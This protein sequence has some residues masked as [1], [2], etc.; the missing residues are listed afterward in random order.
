M[1][2]LK[3]YVTLKPKE[4]V[5]SKLAIR[6]SDLN[7]HAHPEERDLYREFVARNYHISRKIQ[8]NLG[9]VIHDINNWTQNQVYLLEAQYGSGKSHFVAFLQL[10]LEQHKT[11]Q[12]M[13][14]KQS[15]TD[16]VQKKL[17]VV[18]IVLGFGRRNDDIEKIITE[19]VE[20][21][22]GRPIIPTSEIKNLMKNYQSGVLRSSLDDFITNELPPNEQDTIR[23]IL[24]T[25]DFN[26]IPSDKVE[27]A[28]GFTRKFYE[29]T[30][31]KASES[32]PVKDLLRTIWED[33]V[34]PHQE[35][36]EGVVYILE[37]FF[38]YTTSW[39]PEVGGYVG[40]KNPDIEH[41]HRS[42]Y[43]T[44]TD[45]STQFGQSHIIIISQDN[46]DIPSLSLMA[47]V[48]K[49][50]KEMMLEPEDFKDIILFR[51]FGPGHE[52]RKELMIKKW[53]TTHRSVVEHFTQYQDVM[54]YFPFIACFDEFRKVMAH[55]ATTRV[56]LPIAYDTVKRLLE[57]EEAIVSFDELVRSMII[58]GKVKGVNK[59]I[60]N[61]CL[62][63]IDLWRTRY[64]DKRLQDLKKAFL[65]LVGF[66]LI[67]R[68]GSK[69]DIA[70]V[71]I[72]LHFQKG[73]LDPLGSHVE[74]IK[75]LL[76]DLSRLKQVTASDEQMDGTVIYSYEEHEGTQSGPEFELQNQKKKVLDKFSDYLFKHHF[77]ISKRESYIARK[78][79]QDLSVFVENLLFR[80]NVVVKSETGPYT[81]Q[82]PEGQD[83]TLVIVP[84][85]NLIEGKPPAKQVLFWNLPELSGASQDILIEDM[86][87][88]EM[89][90]ARVSIGWAEGRLNQNLERVY[91][92]LR[93][94][95]IEGKIENED[96]EVN[97]QE[98]LTVDPMN[99]LS[100]ALKTLFLKPPNGLYCWYDNG[101]DPKYHFPKLSKK[102]DTNQRGNLINGFI[103][104]GE[105]A[106]LNVKGTR[107]E[108]S[109]FKSFARDF[110]IVDDRDPLNVTL[111]IK[112]PVCKK[113]KERF[114]S[115]LIMNESKADLAAIEKEFTQKPM[116]LRKEAF[117]VY[118]YTLVAKKNYEIKTTGG[119]KISVVNIKG[120]RLTDRDCFEYRTIKKTDI[121]ISSNEL[122]IDLFFPDSSMKPEDIGTLSNRLPKRFREIKQMLQDVENMLQEN[123]F[124]EFFGNVPKDQREYLSAVKTLIEAPLAEK[125]TIDDAVR[126]VQDAGLESLELLTSYKLFREREWE[127]LAQIHLYLGSVVEDEI[128]S[129][130]EN[131]KEGLSLKKLVTDTMPET[132]QVEEKVQIA[133]GTFKDRYVPAH[134]HYAAELRKLKKK[135]DRVNRIIENTVRISIL[136]GIDNLK[137]VT[138]CSQATEHIA[139]LAETGRRCEC[140]Y[141]FGQEL[142]EIP[143][144]KKIHEIRLEL[145]VLAKIPELKENRYIPSLTKP[146]A[147]LEELE[148]LDESLV[149]EIDA[150]VRTIQTLNLAEFIQENALVDDPEKLVEQFRS[151]LKTKL[152]VEDLK[153][154][155]KSI[156]LM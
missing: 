136:R 98:A 141:T 63:S 42:M 73:G 66:Y 44:L 155:N 50:A 148:Y 53:W 47:D 114:D 144:D 49:R 106:T 20:E 14:R 22:L 123:S 39:N 48:E 151:Y 15:F 74:Y 149:H 43:R 140:G 61:D 110:Q 81:D 152:A 101:V 33:Y 1:T 115:E 129:A 11:A 79:K 143:Y 70:R 2:K 29:T 18:P 60:V 80:G 12:E 127:K 62:D 17:F 117:D 67:V 23:T 89:I 131:L 97:K 139:K 142:P 109:A 55:R 82:V 103:K 3:E 8:T 88:R 134:N 10:L 58:D 45:D 116:G 150:I 46:P 122:L 156:R 19:E 7:D 153:D 36:Y 34:Q 5:K 4:E 119:N 68:N 126:R 111:D 100:S 32:L 93:S 51:L 125:N 56:G 31:T 130:M 26:Q 52:N 102:Y 25:T 90:D 124:Q 38:E 108:Q 35:G 94:L 99:H 83:F 64:D 132:C 121:D 96:G 57:E 54:T 91:T 92:A 13:A 112:N 107:P 75:S 9:E 16:M 40:E 138:P 76:D 27:I 104:Y 128:K 118:L 28:L 95:F 133:Y 24:E 120:K 146:N 71:V 147:T 78:F 41:R 77:D 85:A 72:P 59:E 84:Y 69:E 105:T 65:T 86:A 6:L 37:E 21:L 154:H 135:V 137:S 30:N 145:Q 113:L 87:L